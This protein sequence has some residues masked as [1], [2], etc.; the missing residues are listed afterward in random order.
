MKGLLV[1]VLTAALLFNPF[2]VF[3]EKI[4][5]LKAGILEKNKQIQELE[6]EIASFQGEIEKTGK[7]ADSL[8]KQISVI[9]STISK[10]SKD[11]SVA[12]RKIE[13]A[14]LNLQKLGIEISAQESNIG[15]LGGG[16]AEMVRGLYELESKS[17]IEVLL[18]KSSISDFF[19]DIDYMQDLSSKMRV[20]L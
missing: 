3:G 13:A 18:A 19:Q 6:E 2:F 17:L 12:Q 8:K 20:K 16:L 14:E 4:D 9:N 7:D 11:I 10:L 5:E 15:E 1:M